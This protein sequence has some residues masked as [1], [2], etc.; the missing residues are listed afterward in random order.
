MQIQTFSQPTVAHVLPTFSLT[1]EVKEQSNHCLY[2]SIFEANGKKFE[3]KILPI[4][5]KG[6]F[7]ILESSGSARVE[8]CE[9]R[10]NDWV[11]YRLAYTNI[12]EASND[13][14]RCVA[15]EIN[16]AFVQLHI[17]K[18]YETTNVEFN[19]NNTLRSISI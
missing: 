5:R 2:T 6:T 14:G 13:L 16:A 7:S 17:I 4:Y 12:V 8:I 9:I 18:E 15:R 3:L 11:Q 10:K 19:E 1:L